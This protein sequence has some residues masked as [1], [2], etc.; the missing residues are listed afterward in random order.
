VAA[1]AELDGWDDS[2]IISTGNRKET[3]KLEGIHRRGFTKE[4]DRLPKWMT[5]STS[6]H[7]AA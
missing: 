5:K 3:I 7:K 2:R 1:A 6:P 4:D